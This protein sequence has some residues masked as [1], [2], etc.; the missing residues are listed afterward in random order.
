MLLW[1]SLLS[2][3]TNLK[4]VHLYYCENPPPYFDNDES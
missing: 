2:Q 4:R 3:L 1:P